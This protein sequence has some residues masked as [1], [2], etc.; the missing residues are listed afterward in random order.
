MNCIGKFSKLFAG[1]ETLFLIDD[2]IADDSLDKKRT[3]M[4]ELA[5]SGRHR[6]HYL[7]LL[8]QSYT[9]IPKNLRRQ[10]KMVF[11]WS[12]DDESDF[13]T[14][15]SESRIKGLRSAMSSIEDAL[16]NQDHACL[17]LKLEKPKSFAIVQDV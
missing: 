10:K 12:L 1:E 8:T 15:V 11:M 16:E 6:S 7:W 5:I 13:E 2:I 4:L 3:A 9:A 17:C 14:I